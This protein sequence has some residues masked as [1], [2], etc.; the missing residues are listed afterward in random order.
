MP[1]RIDNCGSDFEFLF[2]GFG[3]AVRNPEVV[4]QGCQMVYFQTKNP[5]LGQ[6]WNALD[7]R[8]VIYFMA[9]CDIL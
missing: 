5:N 4:M 6:F 3:P 1:N 7:W 2:E 8:M 9:I